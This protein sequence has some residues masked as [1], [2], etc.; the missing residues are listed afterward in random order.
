MDKIIKKNILIIELFE[1]NKGN[2]EKVQQQTPL[3]STTI[4]SFSYLK[5]IDTFVERF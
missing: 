1:S 2:K 3:Q 4:G 5:A